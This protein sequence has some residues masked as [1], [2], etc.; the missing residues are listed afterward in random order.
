MKYARIFQALLLTLGAISPATSLA[1]G[2]DEAFPTR[3]LRFIVPYN[4]GSSPDVLVRRMTQHIGPKITQPVVVENKAGGS[5]M[6]GVV[7]L[8]RAAPDGHTVGMIGISNAIA[9][10]ITPELGI[11]LTRDLSGISLFAYQY[12]V[13]VVSPALPANSVAEFIVLLKAKPGAYSFASGGSGTPGHLGAELFRRSTGVEV[14]HVPYKGLA[15]A[16]IDMMRG[17]IA[18]SFSVVG[19]AAPVVKGGKVRALAVTSPSRLKAFPD[20][21]TLIESGVKDANMGTWWGIAAPSKTPAAAVTRL[22]RLIREAVDD[23]QVRSLFESSGV[24]PTTSTAEQFDTLIRTD[25]ARWAKLS[26]ELNLKM[27]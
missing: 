6:L 13:L 14:V 7:E 5:G 12:L 2:S 20:V 11:N 19:S 8:T 17:D 25:S 16:F 4:A 3:T 24:E 15:A 18:Y 9:Q 23:A 21:P 1:Q 22:N 10:W 26:K 27:D